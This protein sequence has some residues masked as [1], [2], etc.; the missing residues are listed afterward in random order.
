[1]MLHIYNSLVNLKASLS[2]VVEVLDGAGLRVP[3]AGA[4]QAA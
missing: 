3:Q 4:G 1:M 2:L